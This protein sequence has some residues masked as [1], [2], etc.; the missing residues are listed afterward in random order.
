MKI[1]IWIITAVLWLSTG[2]TP[3]QQRLITGKVTGADDKKPIPGV[4]ILLKGSTTGTTSDAHGKY[5]IQVPAGVQMLVFSYIGYT[6]QEINVGKNSIIDVALEIDASQLNEVVIIGAAPG[7][8]RSVTSAATISNSPRKESKAKSIAGYSNTMSYDLS[9]EEQPIY[10]TEEYDAINENIF[11]DASRN[12]LSTFSID[13]DAASYSNIRRFINNGQR[14][15][16]D[17]V[18][19]E[20]MVNYFSYDY[21]QPRRRSICCA[22]RN[23]YGTLE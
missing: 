17:A 16:K 15:P 21:E 11:H 14:P 22:H 12:P 23:F 3:V 8:Q 13:V 10:N 6:T 4:G 20:E 18:R 19:I 1:S 5:S 2:F 7:I 9:D